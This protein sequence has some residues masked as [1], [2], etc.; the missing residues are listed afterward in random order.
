MSFR[1]IPACCRFQWLITD[2]ER[3]AKRTAARSLFVCTSSSSFGPSNNLQEP[4]RLTLVRNSSNGSLCIRAEAL[5]KASWM[6]S[7][8]L[9]LLE[10]SPS[11]LGS[12]TSRLRVA[13]ACET[14]VVIAAGA[15]N[16]PAC[17]DGVPLALDLW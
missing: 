15:A 4:F 16:V 14:S 10:D 6:K 13:P 8:R 9:Y 1:C 3:R 12:G 7:L 17:R 5:S 11:R 2:A